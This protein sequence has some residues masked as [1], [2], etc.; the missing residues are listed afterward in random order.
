MI[1]DF[2][3]SGSSS[4]PNLLQYSTLSS[5]KLRNRFVTPKIELFSKATDI[6]NIIFVATSIMQYRIGLATV[7]SGL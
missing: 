7:L 6:A 5:D 3:K 1:L 4:M 2:H